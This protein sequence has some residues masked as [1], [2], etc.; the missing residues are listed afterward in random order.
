[1]INLEKHSGLPIL[2]REDYSLVFEK[3]LEP[4][5][6]V[7]RE[8]SAMKNYLKNPSSQYPGREVYHMYRDVA[9]R[10]HKDE[11]HSAGL[12]YDITVIPPGKI[13]N[14][15]VKTIGHYHPFKSGTEVRYP[16]IYEVIYGRVF[17]LL[18]S[19]SEDFERLNEVYLVRAGRG[20][21]VLVPPGFGHVS[22]NPADDVLVLSNWQPLNNKGIYEPY[23]NHNGAAYYVTQRETL[24]SSGSTSSG[25]EFLPNLSYNLVP[26]LNEVTPRELPQYNLLSAI[27]MYFTATQNLK[28]L[29]FLTQPENYLDELIPEKLFK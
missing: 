18:Q 3:G 5:T 20:E 26:K 4:V 23:E 17:L 14:E 6:A 21:K 29:D 15:F 24:T 28:T 9:I 16:E 27:P 2:M 12:E 11:I 10:D 25:F 8:F 22:I 19:A 7:S 13:G 1:M